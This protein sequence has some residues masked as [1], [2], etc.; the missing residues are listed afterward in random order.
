MH[1]LCL[2]KRNKK[3]V[4]NLLDNRTEKYYKC[5]RTQRADLPK[6]DF[7][8]RNKPK[9]PSLLALA[10]QQGLAFFHSPFSKKYIEPGVRDYD[11]V[12]DGLNFVD[13]GHALRVKYPYWHGKTW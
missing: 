12:R 2:A 1:Y 6:K 10:K 11:Y 8:T 3:I 13:H 7:S 9:K 5:Y 4:Y